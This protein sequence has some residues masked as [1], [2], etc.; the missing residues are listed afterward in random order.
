MEII[1]HPSPNFSSRHGRVPIGTCNHITAG[2]FP[3]CLN[4]LC[5]PESQASAHYL[6]T[7]MGVIY[8]LVADENAA[9]H[10]GIVNRPNWPLYDGTNPNRYLIGIENENLGGGQLTELQYQANL[11][12]EKVLAQKWGYPINTDT[13]IGHYRIDSVNRPNCPGPNFPWQRLFADLTQ[14]SV[15]IAV[16][17]KVVQCIIVG[18]RSY[19]P[20]RVIAQILGFQYGWQPQPP[21]VIIG[22]TTVPVV[23]QGETGYAKVN[24]LAAAIGRQVAWD[25]PSNTATIF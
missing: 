6:I 8:Q 14:Q 20:I 24:E 3:G 23:I 13:L 7:Q 19:A 17:G 9:W 18:D 10:A 12:L 22:S 25:G 1:Q 21:A 2:A 5:N 16:G 15:N 4:W 11:W